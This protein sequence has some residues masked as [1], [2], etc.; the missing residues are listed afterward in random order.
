MTNI[1][2]G[3][4]YG[5]SSTTRD[6]ATAVFYA[7]ETDALVASTI[8]KAQM[9]MVDRG[10]DIGFLSQFPGEQ[11]ILYGPLMGMEVRGTHVNGST[12]VVEVVLSTNQKSLTLE[13]VARPRD[14]DDG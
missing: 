8:L 3:V 10:A 13:Q 4:E 1:A 6:R 12:L 2:G 7:K 14:R 11:E 9:G 5:F